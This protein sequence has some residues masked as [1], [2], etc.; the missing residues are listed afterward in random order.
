MHLKGKEGH[1]VVDAVR[2]MRERGDKNYWQA[3]GLASRRRGAAIVPAEGDWEQQM[4]EQAKCP[5]LEI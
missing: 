1:L 2:C 5:V 3:G 4:W